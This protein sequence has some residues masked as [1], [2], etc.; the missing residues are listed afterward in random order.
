MIIDILNQDPIRYKI[1][2]YSKKIGQVEKINAEMTFKKKEVAKLNLNW[3]SKIKTRKITVIGSKGEATFDD[4]SN[5]KISLRMNNS[6]TTHFPEYS[7]EQ[8]LV[9]ELKEFVNAIKKRGL[10]YSDINYG[11]RVVKILDRIE[12]LISH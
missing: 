2:S 1:I 4:L 3:K 12:N 7:L 10:I 5:K 6:S 9:L 11:L 8:P